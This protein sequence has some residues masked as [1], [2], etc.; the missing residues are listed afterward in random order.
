MTGLSLFDGIEHVV[1]DVLLALTPLVLFFIAYQVISLRLPRA[2]VTGLF[3]GII[4]T[5]VGM[6]F[7][8]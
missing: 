7:F 8:F 1:L 2:Y 4:I 5:L 3:K 6:V